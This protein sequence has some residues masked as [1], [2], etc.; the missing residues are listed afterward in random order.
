MHR[1]IL[2]NDEIQEASGKLLAPGQ[3]GLLSGWGVFST[4]RVAEGVLFAFEQHWARMSKDAAALRVS[5]PPESEPVRRNLLKLV[6]AN[7]AYNATMRLVVVRNTGGMWEGPGSGRPSDVIA[8][9]AETKGWGE[10]VKLCWTPRARYAAGEFAGAKI[11]S[12]A[13]NLSWLERAQDRGFDETILL[14][15]R[16]EVAECTSANIFAAVGDRVWTPEIGSGCL[17]GV[18]RELLLRQIRV[19]GYTIAERT[20]MPA[21]LERADEV[22]ITSTTRNLLP[23]VELEGRSIPHAGPACA[24]LRSAFAAYVEEY[25]RDAGARGRGDAERARVDPGTRRR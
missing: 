8:L 1:F 21:D 3:V 24:A 10:G 6:E 17:P 11:L 22:F 9:T 15:E 19:P 2:H 16:G 23:V 13:M 4:M 20:L 7:Q 14:N 12:W 5:L 18:T 25:V